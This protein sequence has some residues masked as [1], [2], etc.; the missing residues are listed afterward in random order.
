MFRLKEPVVWVPEGIQCALVQSERISM[1]GPMGFGSREVELDLCVYKGAGKAARTALLCDLKRIQTK[2][3]PCL[4]VW[5]QPTGHN[6]VWGA[7]L[8]SRPLPKHVSLTRLCWDMT[9]GSPCRAWFWE[10]GT[11]GSELELHYFRLWLPRVFLNALEA[12]KSPLPL[13]EQIL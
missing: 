2:E 5:L 7:L 1:H 13:L 4:Y 8:T 11:D 12:D 10:S 3:Y 9:T 6:L